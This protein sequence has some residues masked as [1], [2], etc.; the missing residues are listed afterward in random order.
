[1]AARNYL[2]MGSSS[3]AA[4]N[5]LTIMNSVKAVCFDQQIFDQCSN[6]ASHAFAITK[7]LQEQ[8]LQTKVL[9]GTEP[10]T[11]IPNTNDFLAI[12]NHLRVT[13]KETVYVG[14]NRQAIEGANMA[15]MISVF[16][17]REE[18][19]L[20]YGQYFSISSLDELLDYL[21]I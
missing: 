9:N 6:D 11:T 1:V 14:N 20:N 10:H 16:L 18:K 15:G 7:L 19:Y 13:P 21:E 12:A 2:A 3:M 8:G 5:Y 4:R 17:D